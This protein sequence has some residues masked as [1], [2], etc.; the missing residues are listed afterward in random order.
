MYD[1]FFTVLEVVFCRHLG[2]HLGSSLEELP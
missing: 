2:M 1:G